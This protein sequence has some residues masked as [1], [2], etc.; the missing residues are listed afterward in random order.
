VTFVKGPRKGN[1][2]GDFGSK[3]VTHIN[4]IYGFGFFF[5]FINLF[6]GRAP[7][8]V[9]IVYS[10]TVI[11]RR[12]CCPDRRSTSPMTMTAMMTTSAAAAAEGERNIGST[13]FFFLLL[14]ERLERTINNNNYII[15]FSIPE[16]GRSRRTHV[17]WN[18]SFAPQTIMARKGKNPR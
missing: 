16:K 7:K 4:I 3:A 14:Y 17:I 12:Y 8:Q 5:F 9:S 11:S 15:L 1:V 2:W 13:I 6:P 18:F 10:F